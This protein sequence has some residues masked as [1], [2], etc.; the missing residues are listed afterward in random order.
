MNSLAQIL[1]ATASPLQYFLD[2][3]ALTHGFCNT[4]AV[5]IMIRDGLETKA[6]FFDTYL[7]EI[8]RGGVWADSQWKNIDHYYDPATGRGI[9]PFGNAADSFQEYLTRALKQIRRG[10]C[11]KAA[12]F[13]GAA[14]HLIQDLCV[15]HHARGRM[16][17]GH[18]DYESWALRH[19]GEYAAEGQGFY[20]LRAK[21]GDLAGVNAHATA[22][23]F[24]AVDLEGGAVDYAGVTAIT[25][26]LAQRSTAGLFE[27]FHRIALSS[28]FSLS[29]SQLHASASVA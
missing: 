17:N 3:P 11:R 1:L 20:L 19:F 23:L 7:P 12:F 15:P 18:Q 27:Y 25:L 24:S 2:K 9:W 4:Q 10:N 6:A 26:P 5:R 29:F 21:I 13:L 8:N 28:S 22:E 16:F 14:A